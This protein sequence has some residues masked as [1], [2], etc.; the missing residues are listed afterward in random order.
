MLKVN[1]ISTFYG[2]VQ[3]LK[4]VDFEISGSEIVSVIGAN[5]ACKST[6]MTCMLQSTGDSGAKQK[7]GMSWTQNHLLPW[8][9]AS[10]VM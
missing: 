9:T 8:S 2:K 1:G 4:G 5:G 7:C 3:A 10:T 6:L